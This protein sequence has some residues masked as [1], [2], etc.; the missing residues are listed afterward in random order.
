MWEDSLT[1]AGLHFLQGAYRFNKKSSLMTFTNI[2]LFD[3]LKSR[4]WVLTCNTQHKKSNKC[5]LRDL[6]KLVICCTRFSVKTKGQSI[7]RDS[8]C[9]S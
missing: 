3:Y 7:W 5:A 8:T 4:C 9:S 1:N 6:A 2:C